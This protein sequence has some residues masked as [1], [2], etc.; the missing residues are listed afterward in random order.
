MNQ[1]QT[2][3]TNYLVIETAMAA[4]MVLED[5]RLAFG[6]TLPDDHPFKAAELSITDWCNNFGAAT[7]R[8]QAWQI[9][10]VIESAWSNMSEAERD[11]DICWDFE[12][13]PQFLLYCV[14]F[15]PKSEYLKPVATGHEALIKAYREARA[16]AAEFKGGPASSHQ[17]DIYI[18]E[19][20]AE[21]RKQWAYEDLVTDDCPSRTNYAGGRMQQAFEM[22]EKPAEFVKWLGEKYD[23]TPA[24]EWQF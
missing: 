9:S 15:N 21:A 1:P 3:T 12:F 14:K 16:K 24:S 11:G 22:G 18:R 7:M 19:C 17:R 23:L 2:I 6:D 5:S 4:Y 10:P 8:D 13:V 20:K